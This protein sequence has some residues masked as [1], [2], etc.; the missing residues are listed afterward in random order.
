ME[1]KAKQNKNSGIDARNSRSCGHIVPQSIW[2]TWLPVFLI[3]FCPAVAGGPGRP[4]QPNLILGAI[5]PL[6]TLFPLASLF[7]RTSLFLGNSIGFG[8]HESVCRRP[9]GWRVCTFCLCNSSWLLEPL[10]K[11][12]GRSSSVTYLISKIN[13]VNC[14]RY[15]GSVL[16]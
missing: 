16:P 12:K 10:Y 14:L 4:A 1:T 8:I 2:N 6:L 3:F 7:H 5:L 15:S 13:A 11:I 9:D